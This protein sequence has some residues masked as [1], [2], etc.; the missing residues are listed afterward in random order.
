M[1]RKKLITG[2][3]IVGII[4]LSAG[5]I[6]ASSQRTANI[7]PP[8][9]ALS[10]GKL[11]DSISVKGLVE[12]EQSSNVYST[13]GLRIKDV[14]VKVGDAVTAGQVL[15]VL[16]TSDLEL[17]I[18]AQKAELNITQK[19]NNN[20][21]GNSERILSEVNYNITNGTNAQ[22]A[23]ANASVK[24]TGEALKTA[25]K[26]YD[27]KLKDFE[28]NTNAQVIS[29]ENALKSAE[30]DLAAKTDAYTKNKMLF[31]AGVIAKN[32]M[33][34]TETAYKASQNQ[35]ESAVSNL[36]NAKKAQQTELDNL[37]AALETAKI[38]YDNALNNQN[39]ANISATQ[40][41]ARTENNL[42]SAKLSA[43][44]DVK[45]INIQKLEKQL[46]DSVITA[47]FSGTITAVYAKEGAL[48]NGLMFVVE[49]L[50]H[51]KIVT[52]I[53]E[54]DLN[55]VKLDKVV[56][57]KSDA[58][59]DEVYEG[60][61]SKIAPTSIKNA[62]GTAAT[63]SNV[64]FEAEVAVL[65]EKTDLKIGMNTRLNIIIEQKEDV[66]YAP[67]DAIT[68]EDDDKTVIYRVT[69]DSNGKPTT[70]AVEITTGLETDFNVEITGDSLQEGML[71][72]EDAEQAA[73]AKKAAAKKR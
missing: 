20:Q 14:N 34:L 43:N 19:N 31:D 8:S 71:I 60:K 57:I 45:L 68:Y 27:D 13:S 37:K 47:P 7:A 35:H 18:A 70:E 28:K 41:L 4:A 48:A 50:E 38:N 65:S 72:A 5:G 26:N 25:Q 58:T 42:E 36:N 6:Y 73:A 10:R 44:Y 59:G 66:Y 33:T 11:V 1:K 56:T 3:I 61:I 21:I 69:E 9:F 12:S 55:R 24:S 46:K 49:D 39:A 53:S 29:A 64:E 2:T 51:L 17:N 63:T 22:I 54:Y 67:Y 23:N 16:D 15:C 52:A 40:E 32:D 30:L 62:A